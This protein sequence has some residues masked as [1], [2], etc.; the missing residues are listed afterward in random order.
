MNARMRSAFRVVDEALD[1]AQMPAILFSGGKESV[2]LH[3]LVKDR[4][5]PHIVLYDEIQ[6]ERLQFI[7]ELFRADPF[8]ILNFRPAARG[9]VPTQDHVD[10]VNVYDLRGEGTLE[11]AISPRHSVEGCVFDW[12]RLPVRNCPD[13]CFDTLI[14]GGRQ[15]DHHDYYGRPFQARR[16]LGTVA[17]INPLYDWSEDD[18]WDAIREYQIPYDRE[19]YEN[20]RET[21]LDTLQ[22][23]TQ[24][25]GRE[26]RVHCPKLGREVEPAEMRKKERAA[27]ESR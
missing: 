20:G 19:R 11:V 10:L 6:P 26:A 8:F 3:H 18:V 22:I 13:F 15:S 1:E 9:I 12:L 4:K 2:V 14:A 7:E 17:L 27:V 5:I 25:F 24:C 16:M 23:C 21:H